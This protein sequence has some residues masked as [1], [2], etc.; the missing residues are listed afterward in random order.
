MRA[1]VV[2]LLA[3]APALAFAQSSNPLRA[4]SWLP[5]AAKSA[6]VTSYKDPGGAFLM[7][8][9]NGTVPAAEGCE[10][11]PSGEGQVILRLQRYD[12]NSPMGR[13]IVDQAKQA[14]APAMEVRNELESGH[15][16]APGQYGAF[17]SST[18]VSWEPI[19]GGQAGSYTV[20]IGCVQATNNQ[21]RITDLRA[22]AI[23][24]GS[25]IKVVVNLAG[26][27][28]QAK[29]YLQE[30]LQKLKSADFGKL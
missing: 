5:A 12:L 26:D 1:A 7:V 9:Q 2:A 24:G 11:A 4:P 22:W 16:G 29:K 8:E 15:A 27:G 17:K 25:V 6:Q 23:Q 30:V 21:Y 28:A 19:E 10:R 20:T 14:N 13:M 18:P 3:C